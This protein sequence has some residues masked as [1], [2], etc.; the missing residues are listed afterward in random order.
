MIRNEY[1]RFMQTLKADNTPEG[2]RKI[3][4]LILEHLNTIQPLTTHQ[5]QRV[6][7]IVRLAQGQWP[8][9]AKDITAEANEADENTTTINRLKS[10]H[11]GPFRGFA[12]QEDFDLDSSL[13]LIYGPN[14]TGKSSFCEALEYGLLGNVAEAES[15]RFR[16]QDYLTNAHVG[17][18]VSPTI[19][20]IDGD[21][22]I[23]PIVSNEALY[24]FCFVEKNRIDNFSRI[25]AQLPARQTELISTLFGLDGFN[26]FVRN[27]TSEI[28]ERYIDLYGAKAHELRQKQQ[29]LAGSNQIIKDNTEVLA[30]LAQQETT[31]ANQYSQGM[32]ITQLV[33]A[34]GNTDAPAEIATLEAEVQQPLPTKTGITVAV[35]QAQQ[36][37]IT[38]YQRTLAE[39]DQALAAASENLSFKQLYE[40]VTA[41]GAV[42]QDECPAC[43]TPIEQVASNPFLLAPQE[44]AKLA[45][46]AQL[47]Q[48]RDQI[49]TNITNVLKLIHQTIQSVTTMLGTEE[50][51][52]PLR[53]F[54]VEQE[55]GIN[56]AWWQTLFNAGD[57]GFTAWQHLLTQAQQLEQ[58]DV[59]VDQAQQRRTQKTERLKFVRELERQATILQTRRKSL[60]EGI[61]TSNQII[62]NF[63]NVNKDLI[64][65]VEP[66]KAIVK[67][68][69]EIATGYSQFVTRLEQY[70]NSLPGQLIA[71]LGDTVVELYNAFN[72]NDAPKDL[73]AGIKLPLAQGQRI[74]ISFQIDPEKY[75]DALHILSEGHI[76]CIG[77]AILM[78][79]NLR[80]NCPILIFD[81]PVNAIDD[82]HR[83][84]IRQTLFQEPYFQEKQIILAIHGNEFFKDTHQLIGRIAAQ[85]SVSYIFKPQYEEEHIQV[86]SLTRPKNYVLAANDLYEQGD[87]RDALMSARRALEDLCTKVWWHFVRNGGG[88][89]SVGKRN[90]DA[91]VDLR[92]LAEKL[93][94]EVNKD[95]YDIPNKEDIVNAF[96]SLLGPNGQHTHWLYLNKGTHEENDRE[97]FDQ[98]VV[99]DIVRCLIQIDTAVQG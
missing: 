63:D 21:G 23:L 54:T 20:A 15:K 7:R 79:K 62:A 89:V 56:Q 78:A 59:A 32:T 40:A 48:E 72:R 35:L 6:R 14:G 84:A 65:S 17:Q 13:V 57:D 3:G 82:E 51:P 50:A 74:K 85:S 69:N 49:Q 87:Y 38:S 96:D 95:R 28:D 67:I 26:E 41:L 60:E 47:Q 8:T 11:V 53:I 66:E 2:V 30:D 24:R 4:N 12:R 16:P 19:E 29:A 45:H 22:E 98:A 80:E 94:S 34:L 46:L 18:F 55:I 42:N 31:L 37:S 10:L 93:K 81:D 58:M 88:L 97:E 92:L 39:K 71:D 36:Q 70:S 75:F 44:L 61:Q 64:A 91:P 83:N 43:K 9:L 86:N 27:F 25:A 73:L 1:L 33:A 77:L 5:G 99:A 52:N 90:P 68:N 76:R